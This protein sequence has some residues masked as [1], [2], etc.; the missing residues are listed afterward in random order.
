MPTQMSSQMWGLPIDFTTSWYMTNVLL[1]FPKI[2]TSK[3]HTQNNIYLYENI[4]M[5]IITHIILPMLNF[6]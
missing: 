4:Q 5:D 3:K 6:K 1:L 2:G